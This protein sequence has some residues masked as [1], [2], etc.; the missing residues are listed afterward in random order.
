MLDF[1]KYIKEHSSGE[2][3]VL[4]KLSRE[5]YA[6]VL[7]P[8]M[9]SGHVQGRF[10]SLISHM[11]QPERILEIGTFTGYS[12]ICMAEGLKAGGKLITIDINEELEDLVRRYVKEANME[13]QIELVYGRAAEVIPNL[14]EVF[15]IVFIDADKAGYSLYFD[16]VIDKVRKGGFI[17]ADNVLWKGKVLD[18]EAKDKDTRALASF[19]DKVQND[20]RVDNTII[21]IRDGLM[22]IRKK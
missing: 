20:Q 7:M 12:A 17:I 14:D 11:I 13:N 3:E 9:L 21:N 15:D 8:N 1:E 16:L 10:L 19:N 18:P 6:D 4:Q 2:P 22:I 5:T